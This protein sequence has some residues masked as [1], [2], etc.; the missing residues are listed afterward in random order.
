[1]HAQHLKKKKNRLLK[2]VS[3]QLIYNHKTSLVV[4]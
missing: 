1:M 3:T 2:A 4:G